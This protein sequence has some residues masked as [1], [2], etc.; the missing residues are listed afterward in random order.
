MG[1]GVAVSV[2]VFAQI[3]DEM[4]LVVSLELSNSSIPAQLYPMSVICD[5]G[6]QSEGSC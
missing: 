2:R 5:T 1:V 3:D 6:L 4:W